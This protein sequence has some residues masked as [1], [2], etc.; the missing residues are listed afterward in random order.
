MSPEKVRT[1]AW[2]ECESCSGH[3]DDIHKTQLLRDGEWRSRQMTLSPRKVAYHLPAWYSPWITWVNV[4]PSSRLER[5]SRETDEFRNSWE[6]VPWVEKYETK[7]LARSLKIH[8]AASPHLPER[9]RLLSP[10]GS[11]LARAAS[12]LR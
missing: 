10:V 12:G 2:Y 8:R 7:R 11:T 1:L 5:L 9:Y 3:I 4:P 6:A